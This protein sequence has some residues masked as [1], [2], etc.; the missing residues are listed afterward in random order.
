MPC[1]RS[2]IIL[3]SCVERMSAL[4][5]TLGHH[6]VQ[7]GSSTSAHVHGDIVDS[8]TN[9]STI[10]AGR[11]TGSD[12]DS[13]KGNSCAKRLKLSSMEHDSPSQTTATTI[14]TTTT[15]T[16]M[17]SPISVRVDTDSLHSLPSPNPEATVSSAFSPDPYFGKYLLFF[18]RNSL[19]EMCFDEVRNLTRVFSSSTKDLRLRRVPD[20]GKSPFA[21]VENSQVRWST[22]RQRK[23]EGRILEDIPESP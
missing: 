11:K 4:P 23:E 2:L 22:L 5:P 13:S 3:R 8:A 7:L 9:S 16:T 14:T 18:A 17:P 1:L 6:T 21:I 12:I 19:S 20:D 15:P 10:F